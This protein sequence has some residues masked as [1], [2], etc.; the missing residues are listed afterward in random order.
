M[1]KQEKGSCNETEIQ[2]EI[3][4]EAKIFAYDVSAVFGVGYYL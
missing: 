3:N 4:E 1:T 2:L